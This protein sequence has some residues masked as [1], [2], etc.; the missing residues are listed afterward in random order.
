MTPQSP[1][2]AGWHLG[3]RLREARE[4]AGLTVVGAAKSVGISQNY[5]SDVEHGKRRLVK[6]KL[7]ALAA[8]CGLTKEYEQELLGMRAESEQHGWW[9]RYSRVLPVEMLR[10]CGLEYGAESI[11]T[12]ES[13]LIPGLLQTEA[14]AH[15]IVTGDGPN[16]RTADAKHQVEARLRRQDR[17]TDGDPLRLTAL[18]SE[19]ALKQRVG[20][21][22]VLREQL[23]HL[24]NMI[25]KLPNTLE[26][27]VVPF[28]AD[29]RGTLGAAT[30]HIL[31]FPS[32]ELP[33]LGWRETLTTGDLIQH[34]VT[35]NQYSQT[36]A[37][38]MQ[39]TAGKKGSLDLIHQELKGLT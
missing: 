33:D 34:P 23:Q 19:G 9:S 20:G 10:L 6:E 4:Q 14:Y 27:L 22:K 17:L 7:S 3:S 39:Q 5:L 26:V 32:P 24:I 16:V 2:V 21:T 12:H 13:L 8:V 28:T 1:V 31:T 36:Y 18:L 37:H 35:I 25:E 38:S 29:V 15:A 30:F 11:R